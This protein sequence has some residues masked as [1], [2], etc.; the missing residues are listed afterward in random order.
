MEE[1]PQIYRERSPVHF[2]EKITAPLLV[3]LSTS[4]R[5]HSTHLDLTIPDIVRI[6]ILQ[7]SADRVVPPN[8]SEMI[9]DKIKQR[10]ASSGG[11]VDS[12]VKYVVFDGEGH[13]WRKSEN[14]KRALEEELAWY[15]K[16]FGL[17]DRSET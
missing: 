4:T 9:V 16:A 5:A 2:A 3:S 14:Q 1:V 7:G 6:Q 15:E 13:G 12:K 11:D 10:V 8:Q 17:G